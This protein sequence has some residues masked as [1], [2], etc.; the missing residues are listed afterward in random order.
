MAKE[1]K[2]FKNDYLDGITI[3]YFEPILDD[4]FNVY[5]KEI[6]AVADVGCGNGLFSAYLKQ[7]WPIKLTGID[8]SEHALESALAKGFDQVLLCDDFSRLP[9]NVEDRSFDFVLNKDVMEHLL[10]PDFLLSE[11]ERVLRPKGLFLLHIPVDFNLWRRLKFVFTNNIDTYNHAPLRCP[12]AKEW[13]WPHVRF[14]TYKGILELLKNHNFRVL[15]DYSSHFTDSVP[16]LYHIPGCMRIAKMLAIRNPSQFCQ[17]ITLLTQKDPGYSS[18]NPGRTALRTNNNY[19]GCFRVGVSN[20]L[21][22]FQRI[23]HDVEREL[24]DCFGLFGLDNKQLPRIIFIAGMALGG[25]SWMKNLLAG[26]PNVFSRKTPMPNEISYRQDICDSAFRHFPKRGHTLVKTH[27]NPSKE[28]IDCIS[29]NG[30]EKIVVTYRDLRDVVVSH[31]YRLIEFPKDEHA[32]D[33]RDYKGMGKEKA[34]DALIEH[35]ASYFVPWIRGW[36]EAAKKEPERF[37][38]IKFEEMI[39]D[40]K[41]AFLKVLDFYGIKLPD[42]KID[43]II[44]STKGRGSMKDNL[45]KERILPAGYVSTFRSGRIGQW[46]EEL[47]WAQI[48][49]CKK[50][51][52][53][54][55]IELGYE[56]NFDWT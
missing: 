24:A 19:L 31:Y 8:A 43:R 14:F 6:R 20:P 11:I 37:C 36:F 41:G 9:L 51:L 50:L 39:R 25:S 38:F 16:L 4:V 26:I 18:F 17:A 44:E 52:G 35:T 56:K 30:V 12:G 23:K 45:Q 7:K 10:D 21:L 22:V 28:N 29:R 48:E 53:P 49:A 40:T 33:F 46:K 47:S 34:I 32:Y 15:K 13:N 54:A 3:N 1:Y 5:G 42:K 27:L 2:Y 55:L